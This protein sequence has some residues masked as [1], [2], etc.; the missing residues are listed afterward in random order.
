MLPVFLHTEN[1]RLGRG[2]KK[3]YGYKARQKTPFGVE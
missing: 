2:F 3:A 1:P